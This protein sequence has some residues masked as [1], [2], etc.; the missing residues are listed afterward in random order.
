VLFDASWRHE[1][2][3][4]LKDVL[5]RG[6]TVQPSLLVLLLKFRTYEIMIVGGL[7]QMY[8][9]IKTIKE[10]TMFWK[11]LW[12]NSPDYMIK[13]FTVNTVNFLH[14]PHHI[15]QRDTDIHRGHKVQQQRI[16]KSI[17][18]GF[19]V[20]DSIQRF[21]NREEAVKLIESIEKTLG[22]AGMHI[23]KKASNDK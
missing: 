11:T 9:Q 19:Y 8:L 13:T 6:P 2:E 12:R 1:R 18:I 7:R 5:D 20:N 10:V 15:C 23:T 17:N 3:R 16:K 14:L 22:K 4:V 21:N